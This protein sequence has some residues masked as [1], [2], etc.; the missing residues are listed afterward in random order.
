MV[1]NRNVHSVLAFVVKILGYIMVLNLT[2][3]LILLAL[4]IFGLFAIVLTYEALFISIIGFFQILCT[5]IYRENRCPSFPA[6][7][8]KWFDFRKF[9]KLKPE[10]RQRYRKEGK[11]MI[12]IG[13]ATCIA[14]VIIHFYITH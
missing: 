13:L 10:E 5:Y 11:I 1:S 2:I 3:S 7:T 12:I 4:G 9:A 8:A 6:V 14:A